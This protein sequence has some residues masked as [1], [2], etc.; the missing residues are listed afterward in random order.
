MTV[1]TAQYQEVANKAMIT[2]CVMLATI[3]EVIDLTI[4][5]V[6]LPHI[7]GALSA[8]QDQITWVVTSYVVSAGIAMPVAG[9]L[10]GKYGAKKVLIY[11][12]SGFTIA[13]LLC[14][15]STSLMQ[16]V[17]FRLM[18]GI[19]GAG[20]VPISQS[21]LLSINPPAKHG[22]AMATWG[23]G[24]MV[25]PILGPMLGGYITDNFDWRW[26]FFINMPVGIIALIGIITFL[27]KTQKD[28]HNNKFDLGG[29]VIFTILIS[30]MQL[31]LDRGEQQDWFESK[32]ITFYAI[33]ATLSLLFFLIYSSGKKDSFIPIRFFLDRNF[34]V[35]TMLIFC[36]GVVL[37][38]S[39][40]IL[41]LFLQSLIGYPVFD[42]G[43]LTAPRGIGT[44]FSMFIVGKLVG[45]VDSRFLVGFGFTM[46]GL[47][48]YMMS[49][50]NLDV[51]NY[52]ISVSGIIQGFGLGFVFVPLSATAFSTLAG[53][54]RPQAAAIFSLVRTIG[55]AV[56]VSLVIFLLGYW[57]KMNHALLSESIVDGAKNVVDYRYYLNDFDNAT[58]NQLLDQQVSTQASLIGYLNSFR[59]T[60]FLSFCALP[61]VLLLKKP[62]KSAGKDGNAEMAMH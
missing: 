28:M 51:T 18:Q 5:N 7:Q 23:I 49:F 15:T 61:L 31:M 58:Q 36:V 59:M 54:D 46:A 1:A 19:F 62:N 50:F 20:L 39:I 24:I 40:T 27:S 25:A 42:S 34:A 43:L 12:I 6:A 13:S 47:S 33:T 60:S 29:F 38:S 22:Q 9:F 55:G 21:V 32:E 45:K 30:T 57:T 26:I 14:G 41:P 56:G 37:F 48:G 44:L 4:A 16:M 8:S 10:A 52:L 17:V 11:C 2:L 53:V 35:S 3:M